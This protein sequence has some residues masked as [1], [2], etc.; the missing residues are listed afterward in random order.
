MKSKF[1]QYYGA[2]EHIAQNA[3]ALRRNETPAEK[4]MWKLLRNRNIKG[5]KFRRQHPI[6]RY[7]ADFYCHEAKLVIELDGDVHLIE[8]IKEYDKKRQEAIS[9][10]DLKVLRFKNEEV[11]FETNKVIEIIEK[12]LTCIIH[13]R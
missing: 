6:S 9:Q 1:P 12:H 4:F 2:T 8:E 10:F 11:F 3:I 5:F 13:K 7:I